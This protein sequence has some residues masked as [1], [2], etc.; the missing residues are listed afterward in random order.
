[1]CKQFHSLRLLLSPKALLIAGLVATLNSTAVAAAPPSS[2]G[3]ASAA[4]NAK[5]AQSYGKLPMSFEA[6]RGQAGSHVKFL[7]RGSGYGL[8]LT[9]QEAILALRRPAVSSSSAPLPRLEAF[10]VEPNGT[11]TMLPL[12]M[13]PSGGETAQ[14]Q[15]AFN[16][17][18]VRMQLAGG[19]P[20]AEP[21]GIDPLPGTANYFLGNDPSQWHSNV[22]TYSKVRYASVYPGVDLI[23]YGSQRQ[24][25]YDFVVAPGASP[26]PIRMHFAGSHGLSLD[27]NGNLSVHVGDG[28]IE[29]ERPDIYQLVNGG[30]R[31]VSGGFRLFA[32]NTAGFSLGRYDHSKPLVIDPI[33]SYSTFL[34][35]TDA[36]YV[37]SVAADSAG[38]AYVTGLTIS[39]DFPTTAGAFQ[40]VNFATAGNQ[41]STAF[42]SKLNASGTALLYST[43]L[44]GNAI[45]NTLHMQGDYGHAIAVDK[46]GNAY[47]TG[48]T[49]SANFPV[50]PGAF[51][52]SSRTASIGQATG[53]VTK[54]NSSGTGLVYSTYLGGSLLDE[55]TALAI[56]SAGDAFVSGLSFSSNFPTT[57][58]AFQSSNRSAPVNGFNAFI[59]KLNPSG[60]AIVYSTY[61]GGSQDTGSYLGSLYWTNPVAVDALGDAYVAGF[62]KSD[63][64][65]VTAGA[66]QKTNKAA[67]YGGAEITLSKL[68]PAGSGLLYS[69]YL[70]GSTNSYSEGLDVDSAGNAY[71]AGYTY[72]LDF[73]VTKGAFQATNKAA[74]IP[75]NTGSSRTNGFLTKVNPAGSMPVYS[76]Y[77]GGTAGPW[78]G[79]GILGLAVDSLG[80]AFVAGYVMSDD[81]PVTA[82]AYQSKNRG[83]THCCDYLTYATNTFLTEFNPTGTGLLYSTYFG[84]SGTQNPFGPGAYGDSAYGVALGGAGVVYTVGA[85]SSSNFPVSKNS[86]E[87]GYHSQQNTGYIAEFDLGAAPATLGTSTALTP[88]A[89]LV[90]PGTVVTFTVA[91]TP[92]SGTGIPSGNVTISV[93][94]ASVATLALSSAGKATWTTSALAAGAHYVLAS[95]AGT[96]TYAASGDGINEIVTPLTPIIAPASGTYEAQQVISMTSPTKAGVIYYTLDGSAPSRFSTLYSGPIV[97]DY[98]T[99]VK[100][101]SVAANDASSRVVTGAYTI[102]DSPWA[103][104][105]PATAISSTGATLNAFL[106]TTGLPG[107]CM[108]LLGT[109]SSLMTASTP[110]KALAASSDRVQVSAPLAGLKSKTT[111]YYQVMATTAAG[112]TSSKVLSFT[113]N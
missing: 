94:E 97:V 35:G 107:S 69:T 98:S 112:S 74:S 5:F 87:T 93:D 12:S 91:V 61:L 60:T 111:Y 102:V 89:N 18:V 44:G 106:N 73:P 14:A 13:D 1:M 33:L 10:G 24:L 41:V 84:G 82:N 51:Q 39:L 90:V 65:P 62:T 59:T 29:L 26:R 46:T 83:A 15:G 55:P 108:F 64:F 30:R 48:W 56:D 45:P 68:N 113:T 101:V 88:S 63:D 49:Y 105:G 32:N 67:G 2:P 80:D 52:L 40:S 9:A 43:Y 53:F 22:P 3:A 66:Y 27:P 23:Y 85:S 86:F 50:T 75:A 7:S 37:V 81:F 58:G 31:P 20:L 103:L 11:R 104:A 110:T 28:S 25:E 34:G 76:T 100:A 8:Y 92:L 38:N 21:V 17:E 72:D 95:Y 47:I 70:G 6:N 4:N 77:L 79:D 78:G 57:A 96:S 71:V 42:I 16:T 109:S 36:E 54:L 19:S 99:T